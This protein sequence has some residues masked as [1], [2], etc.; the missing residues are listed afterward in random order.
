MATRGGTL[1]QPKTPLVPGTPAPGTGARVLIVDDDYVTKP[2]S[3][4][5]LI[6]RIRAILRRV[7]GSEHVSGRLR[8][9]DLEMDQD[10]HEVWRDGRPVDLTA[11]EF[12]LLRFMME[13]PRRVLSK[14]Q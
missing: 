13:N 2:F 14:G 6:A 5:E 9:E 8:F 12:N 4:E 10:T 7:Q 11:T 3:L 1:A